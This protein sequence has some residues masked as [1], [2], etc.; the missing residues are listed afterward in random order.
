MSGASGKVPAALHVTPECLAGGPLA[1]VRD[2]DVIRLDAEQGVLEARVSAEELAA[3][4]PEPVDLAGYRAGLGRELFDV[5]RATAAGAEQGGMTYLPP[6]HH[7]TEVRP[8]Q[9]PVH[10]RRVFATAGAA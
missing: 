9:E 3:R 8:G 1:R 7:D 2:G 10:D 5:F 6:A 4:R